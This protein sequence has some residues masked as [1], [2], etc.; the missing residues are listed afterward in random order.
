[1][2]DICPITAR[3]PSAFSAVQLIFNRETPRHRDTGSWSTLYDIVVSIGPYSNAEFEFSN[4]GILCAYPPGTVIALCG[5]VL[6]HA[7][8]SFTGE[9][10]C[11]AYF[12]R[13]STLAYAG[14]KFPHWMERGQYIDEN[15]YEDV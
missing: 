12:M 11:Y 14:V 6:R 4:A 10:I 8:S 2:P 3:W 13:E 7:V 9:R 1:M 5:K 15:E